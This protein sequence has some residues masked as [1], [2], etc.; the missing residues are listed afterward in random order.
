MML[1]AGSA[2]C[3]S[4][5]ITVDKLTYEISSQG[6]TIVKTSAKAG[7]VIKVPRA[8]SVTI[9]VN[10]RNQSVQLPVIRV[11]NAAFYQSDVAEVNL[12]LCA[13]MTE[14]GQNAFLDCRYMT[15]ITLPSSLTTIGDE[16]FAN[17]AIETISLPATVTQIGDGPLHSCINLTEIKVAQGN[18]NYYSSDGIL[19]GRGTPQNNDWRTIVQYPAGKTATE[20]YVPTDIDEICTM[21]F[22]NCLRLD[23]IHLPEN[24]ELKTLASMSLGGTAIKSITVPS[25]VTL[26]LNGAIY[27]CRNLERIDVAEGNEKYDSVDGVLFEKGNIDGQDYRILMQYPIGAPSWEYTVSGNIDEIAAYAFAYNQ[28]LF[29]VHFKDNGKLTHIHDG[30]FQ[31]CTSLHSIYLPEGLVYLGS[32]AFSGSRQLRA[33]SLPS[34]LKRIRYWTFDG[35][36]ELE[37]VFVNTDEVIDT[38]GNPLNSTTLEK[39]T[40]VFPDRETAQKYAEDPCWNS[41]QRNVKG[42]KFCQAGGLMYKLDDATLTATLTNLDYEDIYAGYVTVPAQISWKGKTYQVKKVDDKT[43]ANS[44]YLILLDMSEA[45]MTQLGDELC[46][47]SQ[48]LYNAYLPNT[49]ELVNT[50]AFYQCSNLRFVYMPEENLESIG[51]FAFCQT[52]LTE[53]TLPASLKKIGEQAFW[54]HDTPINVTCY[55]TVPPVCKSEAT[56]STSQAEFGTLAV[57]PGTEDAYKAATGWKGFFGDRGKGLTEPPCYHPVIKWI[58]GKLTFECATP[59]ARLVIEGYYDK[60][61]NPLIANDVT[62]IYQTGKELNLLYRVVTHAEADGYQPSKRVVQG[63]WLNPSTVYGDVNGDGVVN[64][65]DVISTVY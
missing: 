38:E 19:F 59:G 26:I 27:G 47:G 52:A 50:M 11:G 1:V 53:V 24:G 56:F 42:E 20:Y 65:G 2:W 12:S 43:F 31:Q 55:A 29:T 36:K 39:L 60:E 33:V 3:Q 7:D 6:L 45:P 57:I 14:I 8:V 48:S 22:F 9:P 25:S 23:N 62:E 37:P 63:L 32:R 44:Q 10:G 41:Y 5:Q 30:A 28:N 51:S 4:N 18:P 54:L 58:D 49:L 15:K 61:D 35:C 16:A 34:T 21:A 64:V 40:L 17:T 46:H 13:Q